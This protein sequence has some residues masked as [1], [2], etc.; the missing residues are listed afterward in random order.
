MWPQGVSTW[1][2][3]ALLGFLVPARLN[4]GSGAGVS[5]VHDIPSVGRCV[6]AGA[7]WDSGNQMYDNMYREK[8]HVPSLASQGLLRLRGGSRSQ[9]AGRAKAR[10]LAQK[11]SSQVD[12][13]RQK[14]KRKMRDKM[15]AKTQSPATRMQE[16]EE[17][18][19]RRLSMIEDRPFDPA[20]DAESM[21]ADERRSELFRAKYTPGQM[22][23]IEDSEE[24]RRET[25][26]DASSKMHRIDV[27]ED[28]TELIRAHNER[29]EKGI[30]ADAYT[31]TGDEW[32]NVRPDGRLWGEQKVPQ[33]SWGQASHLH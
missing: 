29:Y 31:E 23:E 15:I 30:S 5:S 4:L 27:F 6:T 32:D 20:T 13:Q 8:I 26:G 25:E 14:L 10:Y 18:V 17:R 9:A 7:S 1:A 19:E 2:L 3:S 16:E 22:V 33:L 28:Q 24:W 21:E 12:V 11:L